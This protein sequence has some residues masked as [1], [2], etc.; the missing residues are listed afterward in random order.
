MFLDSK[1]SSAV[2][3]TPSSTVKVWPSLVTAR[4]S[5]TQLSSLTDLEEIEFLSR[6]RGIGNSQ[7]FSFPRV[8]PASFKG[9]VDKHQ[10]GGNVGTGNEPRRGKQVEIPS[11]IS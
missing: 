6:N 5:S 2:Q 3:I 9:Y 10:N 8:S 4:V 7:T 1:Q 11:V